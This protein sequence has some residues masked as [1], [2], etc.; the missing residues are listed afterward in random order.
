[1]SSV[2]TPLGNLNRR[3][4]YEYQRDNSN[5]GRKSSLERGR[6]SAGIQMIALD[7]GLS[8]RRGSISVDP[9]HAHQTGSQINIPDASLRSFI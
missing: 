9:P 2:E 3:I 8:G 7:E 1:M 4:R 5:G 6:I